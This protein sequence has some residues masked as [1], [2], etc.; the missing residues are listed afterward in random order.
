MQEYIADQSFLNCDFNR[1]LIGVYERRRNTD[2]EAANFWR[3]PAGGHCRWGRVSGHAV[4]AGAS[5][6]ALSKCCNCYEMYGM[7]ISSSAMSHI[8]SSTTNAEKYR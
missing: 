7:C 1:L 2:I 5:P 4:C 3:R 8:S 6:A